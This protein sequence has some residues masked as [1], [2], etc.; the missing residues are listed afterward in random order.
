MPPALG[1]GA[2]PSVSGGSVGS[3]DGSS[4]AKK[5]LTSAFSCSTRACFS[6]ATSSSTAALTATCSA[7]VDPM[8]AARFGMRRAVLTNTTLSWREPVRATV[9]YLPALRAR[10]CGTVLCTVIPTFAISSN[11][12]DAPGELLHTIYTPGGTDRTTLLV[13]A[14]VDIPV[15]LYSLRVVPNRPVSME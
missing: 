15:T 10:R 11:R 7:S 8:A 14:L 2:P 9:L 13:H 12:E 6:F 5:P 4:K 3:G 1:C